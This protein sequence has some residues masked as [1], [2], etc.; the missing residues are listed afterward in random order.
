MDKKLTDNQK[1]IFYVV[2]GITVLGLGGLAYYIYTEKSG[3]GPSKKKIGSPRT[4]KPVKKAVVAPTKKN[5][6]NNEE[7]PKKTTPHQVPDPQQTS[8]PET[9]PHPHPHI[10]PGIIRFDRPPRCNGVLIAGPPGAGK[11]TQC[12]LIIKRLKYKH[13]STG[14]L[15]RAQ[16]EEG[17]DLG[18]QAQDFMGKG[19]LVPD[20][21]VIGMVKEVL[22]DPEV[23]QC[24]WMLDGYPRTLAQ[25]QAMK[26]N[27]ILI[28]KMIILD[29]EDQVL[30]KR[31]IGRRMDPETKQIYHLE[32][33][34]PPG[35]IA[36]RL[37]I[38]KD[39]N[40]DAL[41]KR[42]EEYH[43]NIELIKDFYG[44]DLKLDIINADRD[45]EEVYSDV[46]FSLLYK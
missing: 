15:L 32:F 29:V 13:I 26:E 34:P 8:N 40:E 22:S 46:A 3:G 38:R 4:K 16:A 9:H 35:E 19:L 12:G 36:H 39:D 33:N 44:N 2:G 45:V 5:N 1:K 25:A 37:I 18:I 31:I 24:G 41:K 28:D 6:T 27:N 14:D 21:L 23:Q 42:L 30:F 17:T 10:E 7:T 43:R 11:G 20:D